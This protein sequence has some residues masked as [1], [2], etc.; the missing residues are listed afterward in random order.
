MN[1]RLHETVRY[2]DARLC[3]YEEVYRKPERQYD[4]RRLTDFLSKAFTG[5]DVLEVACGTGYWTQVIARSARS[6]V[7]TDISRQALRMARQKE[8]GECRM[9]F[10]ESDAYSLSNVTSRCTAGFHAFWWSHIPI[11]EVSR[12]LACFHER[13]EEGWKVIMI[14]NIYV[15]GSSTPISRTDRHGN[16]FQ[17]R[18]LKDGSKHEVLKNFP[19]PEDIRVRLRELSL[20]RVTQL[21][22]YWIAEYTK[23]NPERPGK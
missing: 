20:L 12:F 5:Q 19:S 9:T 23:R 6:I 18:E 7:A 13:L 3:E 4:L 2:Y 8:Y 21:Q 15:E 22:Y 17:V 11:Q 16:T 1:V 10:L 14:D